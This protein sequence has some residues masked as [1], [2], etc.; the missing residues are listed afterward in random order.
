[1]EH[2]LT[3]AEYARRNGISREAVRQAA[4]AGR[5]E[6][7]GKSGRD[8][9]VRGKL[10]ETVRTVVKS[11]GEKSE[12]ADAKL[13]KLRADIK[14]QEQKITENIELSR[15]SYVNILVEEYIRAFA[16]LK[17]QLTELHLP[18]DKLAVLTALIDSCLA[19]FCSGVEKKLNEESA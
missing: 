16:P 15:R 3:M 14:L 2:W 5:I 10:A 6:T 19:E 4:A 18:A 17:V 12:L 9:R 7:N 11:G 13:E 1:M 8:C